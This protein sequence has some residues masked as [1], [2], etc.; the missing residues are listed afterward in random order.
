MTLE[1]QLLEITQ[2]NPKKFKDRQKLLEKMARV[3]IKLPDEQW[4]KLPD[5]LIT[6]ADNAVEAIKAKKEIPDLPDAEAEEVEVEFEPEPPRDPEDDEDDED[7]NG[8]DAGEEDEPDEEAEADD[9]EVEEVEDQDEVEA[10]AAD[11]GD[12]EAELNAVAISEPEPQPDEPT[13]PAKKQKKAKAKKQ[14]KPK[15]A[16]V[17]VEEPPLAPRYANLSGLK[18]RYGFYEGTKSD[19][20]CKMLEKGATMAEVKEALGDTKYNVL[21]KLRQDGHQVSQ[22]PRFTLVHKDDLS[23]AKPKGKKR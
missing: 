21:R 14:A 2:I 4:G 20:T 22:G 5:P 7:E 10:A 1:E 13:T 6:W 11:G 17:E 8:D 23:E 19:D 18:N 9:A 16:K 3:A 12:G 15:K